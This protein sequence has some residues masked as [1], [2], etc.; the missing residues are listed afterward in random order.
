MKAVETLIEKRWTGKTHEI[1]TYRFAKQ[2][3]LRD[4]EDVLN[5]LDRCFGHLKTGI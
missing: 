2:V 1:D 3:P 5:G 4:S